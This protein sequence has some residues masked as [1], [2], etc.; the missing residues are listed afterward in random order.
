LEAAAT[1]T[2]TAAPAALASFTADGY[3]TIQI[4][5]SGTVPFTTDVY[6]SYDGVSQDV[7]LDSVTVTDPDGSQ[8]Y[9]L[10][11]EIELVDGAAEISQD[12]Y[13]LAVADSGATARF[14][15]AYQYPGDMVF[16]HGRDDLRDTVQ[17]SSSGANLVIQLNGVAY[18]YPAATVPAVRVRGHSLNDTLNA[19][20]VSHTGVALYL[21]GGPGADRLAGGKGNDVL[22]GG[23]GN[24]KL[25]GKA[26]ADTLY[27]GYGHDT[28]LGGPGAD[29]LYG[30][31]GNDV[32]HAN[33]AVCSNDSAADT[34]DG[35]DHV[36]GDSGT[37]SPPQDT[38]VAVET[39]A[40]CP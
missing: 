3:T 9:V 1:T 8:A 20:K 16:V 11:T 22:I 37:Y 12:Y 19:G 23:V 26:G 36:S 5:Y 15:G 21:A 25:D 27:G 30:E 28:L 32:L 39:L 31:A 17:L 35:G 29:T 7:L 38:A 10:G 40:T 14:A 34:L 6:L 2:I 24:D 13:L 4:N 18:P 33:M